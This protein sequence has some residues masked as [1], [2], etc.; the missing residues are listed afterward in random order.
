MYCDTLFSCRDYQPWSVNLF[1]PL[2]VPLEMML[3][4]DS[5]TN[6]FLWKEDPG[7]TASAQSKE[8]AKQKQLLLSLYRQ[9]GGLL[10]AVSTADRPL[11]PYKAIHRSK[12]I[13]NCTSSLALAFE[14]IRHSSFC[15][16]F[17]SLRAMPQ[18]LQPAMSNAV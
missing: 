6:P 4:K 3:S 9:G 10:A 8:A 12:V 11:V 14:E 7:A 5:H 1:L 16:D 17:P 13:L 18:P 2:T 15:K